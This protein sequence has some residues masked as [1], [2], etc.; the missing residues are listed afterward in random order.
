MIDFTNAATVADHTAG[1]IRRC[2]P[3][4][5]NKEM[6]QVKTLV[7]YV[8][9]AS[10]SS[11]ASPMEVIV[12]TYLA[13]DSSVTYTS[14]CRGMAS[15]ADFSTSRKIDGLCHGRIPPPLHLE[16]LSH[17]ALPPKIPPQILPTHLRQWPTNLNDLSTHLHRSLHS[18]NHPPYSLLGLR[19]PLASAP[20]LLRARWPNHYT[21]P[22]QPTWL[23][24]RPTNGWTN[25]ATHVSRFT[26]THRIIVSGRPL[27]FLLHTTATGH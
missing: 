1:G 18:F 25:A 10:T 11:G 7:G 5:L 8:E 13:T 2:D 12:S 15:A 3:T 20:R 4:D 27:A 22:P 17:S 16:S 19:L 14:T 26:R 24:A 21:S 9:N 23:T 6:E